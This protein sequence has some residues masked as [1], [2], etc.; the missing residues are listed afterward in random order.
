MTILFV[1]PKVGA[2]ATHGIHRSP[3]QLYAHWASF[4]REKGY[5]DVEV[6]D[7]KALE[8]PMDEM[9]AKIKD[10]NPD[11]VVLGEQL[12]SYGGY[13]VLRHFNEAAKRIREVLPKAKIIFGGLWYSAM[14][15]KTLEDNPAVDFVVMGEEESFYDLIDA[16]A[17]NKNLKDFFSSIISRLSEKN[18]YLSI[19]KDC[20]DNK[21]A[22]TN[23]EE[24]KLSIEELLLMLKMIKENLNIVGLDITGDYSKVSV[25]GA[26]KIFFSR[27]DHPKEVRAEKIPQEEITGINERANLKILENLIG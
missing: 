2:W 3:N 17:K 10:K 13:G 22:I 18:V 1:M 7:G 12:H 27:L 4:V 15:V 26:L 20:L 5:E 14:P 21:S 11:I 16:I 6:I 25:R 9:I 8:I 23:W 19:D 24:G